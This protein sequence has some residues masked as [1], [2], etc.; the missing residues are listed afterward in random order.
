MHNCTLFVP[1]KHNHLI[2]NIKYFMYRKVKTI[3]VFK[4]SMVSP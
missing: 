1:Q 2:I 3:E 4:T